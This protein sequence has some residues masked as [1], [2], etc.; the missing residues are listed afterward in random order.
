MD[1]PELYKLAEEI[2][3][4]LD[5]WQLEDFIIEHGTTEELIR[6]KEGDK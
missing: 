3:G 5:A 2:L 1:Y 6:I 4:R